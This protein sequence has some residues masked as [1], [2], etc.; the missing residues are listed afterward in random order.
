MKENHKSRYIKW[1]F[2]YI[3]IAVFWNEMLYIVWWTVTYLPPTRH[4]IA[5]NRNCHTFTVKK[6]FQKIDIVSL[7]DLW[8][9]VPVCFHTRLAAT[10]LVPPASSRLSWYLFCEG[11]LL[12]GW[13]FS[14]MFG[15]LFE[16]NI[17]CVGRMPSTSSWPEKWKQYVLGI[18]FWY[19]IYLSIAQR[20]L[21]F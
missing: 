15:N 14:H 5:D 12:L 16:M 17:F 20:Q 6:W 18:G 10:M 3:K 9:S 7:S 11:T 21:K 19:D 8:F 2:H 13:A 1:G 4:R